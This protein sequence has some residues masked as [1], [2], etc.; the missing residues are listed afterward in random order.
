[1]F[2]EIVPDEKELELFEEEVFGL[3]Q[4]KKVTIYEDEN[5]SISIKLPDTKDMKKITNIVEK[6]RKG[7]LDED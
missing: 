2:N 7:E 3:L 4:Y 5:V 6:Y 1:M